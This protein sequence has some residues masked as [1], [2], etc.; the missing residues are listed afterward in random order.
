ML[1]T[2][3]RLVTENEYA[4]ILAFWRDRACCGAHRRIPYLDPVVAAKYDITVSKQ[5]LGSSWKTC[6][7]W[8][9]SWR[10]SENYATSCA[11]LRSRCDLPSLLVPISAA[12]LTCA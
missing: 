6:N 5:R 8:E 4:Q 10:S 2:S 12:S 9:R 11:A 1:S 7:A 3:W